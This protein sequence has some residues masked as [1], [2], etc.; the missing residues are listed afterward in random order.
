MFIQYQHINIIFYC[1][2][3]QIQ[4][5]IVSGIQYQYIDMILYL[6]RYLEF[7]HYTLLTH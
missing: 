3:V 7:V 6:Y 5:N 4:Y 1:M 2:P